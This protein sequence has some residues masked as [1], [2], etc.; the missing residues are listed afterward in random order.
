MRCSAGNCSSHWPENVG[1]ALEHV[2]GV[3][4]LALGVQAPEAVRQQG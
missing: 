4:A 1:I 2:F 3:F